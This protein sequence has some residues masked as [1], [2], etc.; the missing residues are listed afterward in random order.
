MNNLTILYMH[1]MHRACASDSVYIFAAGNLKVIAH[2]YYLI[3]YQRFET[4]NKC[5]WLQIARMEIDIQLELNFQVVSE[6]VKK[7]IHL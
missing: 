5:L 7:S 4:V 6:R 2:F 3:L 1:D